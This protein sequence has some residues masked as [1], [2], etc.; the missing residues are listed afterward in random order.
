MTDV[1]RKILSLTAGP[2]WSDLNEFYGDVFYGHMKHGFTMSGEIHKSIL[3][4]KY[5][6]P[7]WLSIYPGRWMDISTSLTIRNEN[8]LLTKDIHHLHRLIA[9]LV[10]KLGII[11]CNNLWFN[12]MKV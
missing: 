4:S 5:V 12:N 1:L 7:A 9:I 10:W 8:I 6:Q 11:T 2:F 3:S